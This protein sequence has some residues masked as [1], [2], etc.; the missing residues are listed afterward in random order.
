MNC[1]SNIEQPPDGVVQYG[2][3][4]LLQNIPDALLA[5][6]TV[7]RALVAIHTQGNHR[8]LAPLLDVVSGARSRCATD[9]ARHF[10]DLGDM[11]LFGGR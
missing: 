7:V 11:A 3:L 5:V 10:L 6:D 9:A 1:L 4:C 8:V 2:Q